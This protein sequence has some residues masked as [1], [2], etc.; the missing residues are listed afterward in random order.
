MPK[1]ITPAQIR[2]LLGKAQV[3]RSLSVRMADLESRLS[4]ESPDVDLGSHAPGMRSVL[5]V[6]SRAAQTDVSV[7][8]RGESGTGKGVLARTMHLES[9][10]RD[11]PFVTI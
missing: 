6:L 8:F 10:R 9:K 11:R 2:H 3:Q 5:E 1:P 4:S 7:L